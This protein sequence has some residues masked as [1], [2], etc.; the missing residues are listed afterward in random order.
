MSRSTDAVPASAC[1]LAAE[2]V[3][4]SA[5]QE[6]E[7]L[8]ADGHLGPSVADRERCA[9]GREELRE[10]AAPGAPDESERTATVVSPPRAGDGDASAGAVPS[11]REQGRA[12]AITGVP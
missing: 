10:R 4:G 8:P 5:E 1:T 3:E 9:Q 11:A 6:P 7:R 12:Q 2:D